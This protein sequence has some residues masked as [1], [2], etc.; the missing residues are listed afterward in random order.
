MSVTKQRNISIPPNIPPELR[1]CFQLAQLAI[2]ESVPNGL[3]ISTTAPLT[4]GG[5]LDANLTLALAKDTTLVTAA[6]LLSR[7]ALTGD[8][9]AA[10]GSNVTAIS[11]ALNALMYQPTAS[12]Q[13]KSGTHIDIIITV[14]GADGATLLSSEFLLECWLSDTTTG[15]ETGTAPDT[16]FTVQ[17]GVAADIPTAS[18]RIR[19]ITNTSG[20]ATIR[21]T[22]AGAAH[23]WYLRTMLNARV[24]TSTALVF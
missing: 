22:H 6:G 3:M 9:T 17:A 18:K 16:G 2:F 13:L 24:V 1:R 10:A 19:A 15:W 20:Q 21:V 5:A 8:V 11:S 7:A 4:G 12:V 14:F 23:T